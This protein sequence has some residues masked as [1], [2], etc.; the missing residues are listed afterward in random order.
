[1]AGPAV[2]AGEMDHVTHHLPSLD[3]LVLY[4]VFMDKRYPN[5]ISLWCSAGNSLDERKK[6]P[7]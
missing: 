7:E 1:M 6:H 3:T 4:R 2:N 5:E